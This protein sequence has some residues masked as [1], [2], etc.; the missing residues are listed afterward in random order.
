MS[1]N[2]LNQFREIW[3]LDF[4]FNQVP[5]NLPI[6]RCMV[7]RELRSGRAIRLWADQLSRLAAPPF[8][9]GSDKL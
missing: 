8:G 1:S 2:P 3:L 6:V 9:A 4:E 7:A 5:G